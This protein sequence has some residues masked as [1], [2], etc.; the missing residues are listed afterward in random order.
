MQINKLNNSPNFSALYINKSVEDY[1]DRLSTTEAMKEI[2]TL[3]NLQ[4]EFQ[5]SKH[6]DVFVYSEKEKNMTKPELKAYIQSK[7]DSDLIIKDLVIG[8]KYQSEYNINYD[9]IMGHQPKERKLKQNLCSIF[10]FDNALECQEQYDKLKN[11]YLANKFMG[12][13]EY[14]RQIEAN[15]SRK[16][17]LD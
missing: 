17:H 13:I 7:D 1:L 10:Y 12:M 3:K 5:D 4:Q 14:A 16:N 15:H 2:D 11:S 9:S 8:N 6:V